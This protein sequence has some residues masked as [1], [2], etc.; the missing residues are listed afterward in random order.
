VA[1]LP[2]SQESWEPFEYTLVKEGNL[3][4]LHALLLKRHPQEK[5]EQASMLG[6]LVEWLSV[7]KISDSVEHKLPI[8][9]KLAFSLSLALC[10][11]SVCEDGTL[12]QTLVQKLNQLAQYFT[13]VGEDKGWGL[14]G[15][16]GLRKQP[17]ASMK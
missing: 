11:K 8:L 7:V 5:S 13:G 15:V 12:E 16:I 3:L 6:S 14:L 4:S 2:R 1:P 17:Q 9:W 10:E